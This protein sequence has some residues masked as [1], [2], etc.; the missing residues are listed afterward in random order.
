MII[1][2]QQVSNARDIGGIRTKYGT[3]QQNR[4]LRSGH[5]SIASAN[6]VEML[7]KRNLRRIIDLRTPTE[8]ANHPDVTIPNVD[9]I[10]ISIMSATTFG[11]SYE[12]LNGEEIAVKLQA[13]IERMINR[14]ETPIDHM[15]IL[16]KTFVNNAYSHAGYGNF[17]KTLANTPVDGAT[18]WH[19]TG[20]K[21]RCGTC[22][23]LLLHCLGA[24]RE[25]IMRDYLQTNQQV[26]SHA[27]S[28]LAK[29]RPHVSPDRLELVQSMLLVEQSYLESFWSE[30]ERLYGSVDAFIANCGVTQEEIDKL[31][32]NYLE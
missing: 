28:I 16:Y 9:Y 15:R 30:I 12:T 10:N 31:R 18:L 1:N 21:D 20:G 22:T 26:L 24:S 7:T 2:L 14:G 29:V 32:K 25:D 13:G 23:A 19:C 27:E 3:V 4:L 11:I 6:D 8:I 5:L 17:I